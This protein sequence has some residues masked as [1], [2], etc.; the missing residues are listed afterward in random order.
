[1]HASWD[2]KSSMLIAS[3]KR[4]FKWI[5]ENLSNNIH[6]SHA[7]LDLQKAVAP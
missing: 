5:S 2:S 3:S 7:H 6:V 4:K 1:M